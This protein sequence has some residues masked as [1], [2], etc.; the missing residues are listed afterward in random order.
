MKK[1]FF[2]VLIGLSLFVGCKNEISLSG[3]KAQRI[4][5]NDSI[6]PNDDVEEFIIPFR[7]YVDSSLN[8]GISYSP[9][10]YSK[11]NGELNTAI[12][13]MMADAVMKQVKPVFKSRTGQTL[14]FV[15]LNHGGIRSTISKGVIT[16]RTAYEVMPFENEIV[17]VGMRGSQ[18]EDLL[19]YLKSSK[20]A[21]PISKEL[22][23]ILNKDYDILS[24]TVNG[25]TINPDRIYYVA[26][27]DYLYDGGDRMNFFQPNE[28]FIELDYK[29]RN[30]LIDY[31]TA[32]DT[33]RASIDKRF[34]RK[35]SR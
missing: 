34:I 2:I 13:N 21:H 7:N 31:F 16:K 24:A 20:R 10:Y 30:V 29:I 32:T 6:P 19:F 8:A 26:T 12:G 33:L 3:F 35:T 4:E 28:L 14:D 15:L 25:V 22:E 27:S 1:G 18:V 23:L 17:V 9:S 11:N 5:I